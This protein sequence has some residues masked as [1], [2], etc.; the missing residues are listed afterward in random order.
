[1]YQGV[2]GIVTQPI[3][4]HKESGTVGMIKG[5]GK[6]V[7]GV[8]LKPAAGRTANPH[9][10]VLANETGL[11]GLA[12]YPLKG[13]HK[14]LRNSLSRSKI[15]DILASRIKQGIGEMV[16]ATPEERAAVIRRWNE[17]QKGETN[18]HA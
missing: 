15:R 8:F 16:A 9:Y 6:G 7:G 11:W 5:V 1:M 18:G 17:L 2:T 4:G 10:S 3:Y 14:S 12:G 13:I